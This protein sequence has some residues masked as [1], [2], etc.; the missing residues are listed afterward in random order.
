MK[1][2]WKPD[3]CIYHDPC[4]DGF[5]S[6]F[7]IWMKWGDSVEFRPTNYGLDIPDQDIDGK[8]IL[9]ADF[10]FKSDILEEMGKRASSIVVLDHHKTAEEELKDFSSLTNLNCEDFIQEENVL[11][12][13][14]M[15]R[16]G[17]SLTWNFCF[18]NNEMPDFFK[19]IEDRDLWNFKHDE[20]KPFTAWLRSYKR[21]FD[22]WSELMHDYENETG[23]VLDQ[24]EAILRA[25]NIQINNIA[26]TVTMKKVGKFENVPVV[27]CPYEFVSDVANELLNRY[28]YA[29]F[30]GCYVDAYGNRTWS[31]RSSDD[32]EDVSEI[33]KSFGGGGHRNAAGFNVPL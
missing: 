25:R 12:Y 10:S 15:Q 11:V 27:A 17:A 30:A 28:T 23:N 29:S 19:Y 1:N 26:D 9:I 4:D 31:L 24:G 16:S 13:F 32:R 8:N 33:A 5:A 6:A 18:P 21:S 3:I 22:I 20:T 2:E 14:D 7:I